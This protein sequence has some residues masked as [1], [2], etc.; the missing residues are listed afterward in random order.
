MEA[1]LKAFFNNLK[2]RIGID[3]SVLD[4]N[5]QWVF[6]DTERDVQLFVDFDGIFC[7][8]KNDRVLA[9]LC[10]KSEVFYLELSGSGKA[11]ESLAKLIL[12]LAEKTFAKPS[13]LT[14]AEFHKSLLL[15]ELSLVDVGRYIRKYSIKDGL[16]C[17]MI[18]CSPNGQTDEAQ[19]VV[20]AYTTD[21]DITV[22]LDD[23]SFA[24]IKFMKGTSD[25]TSCAEYAEYIVQ[26]IFDE[27]GLTVF[28]A[29]G[30]MVKSLSNVSNSFSQASTAHRMAEANNC[31]TGVHTFKQYIIYRI[32]E[33]L[34]R[35]KLNEYIKLLS[36]PNAEEIFGDNEMVETA[37]VFLD[38]SLNQSEAARKLFLHRNTLNYR[39]DKIEK[40]TGLN[41]RKFSDAITFRIIMVIRQLVK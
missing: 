19:N 26:S 12:E 41:I 40:S 37:E 24:L 4:R 6:G 27:L 33:D 3:F 5:K 30:G 31:K 25:Y 13:V 21:E 16:C 1:E 18:V 23:N 9:K 7:D 29:M 2:E 20:N 22:K 34:P 17:A 36:D 10:V 38:E 11:E 32:L 14:A 8:A 39:L 35:Y 15:G 28:V